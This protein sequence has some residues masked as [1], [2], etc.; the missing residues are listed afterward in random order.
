AI[1][2]DGIA[3]FGVRASELVVH[4]RA[5]RLRFHRIAIFDDG[6]LD[7]VVRDITIAAR[8]VLVGPDLRVRPAGDDPCQQ[9]GER[10]QAFRHGRYSGSRGYTTRAKSTAAL[11]LGAMMRTSDPFVRRNRAASTISHSLFA[12]SFATTRPRP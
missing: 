8:H 9:H 10:Q 5:R 6:V 2:S 11:S 7:L 4:V 3:D 12:Y 1:G